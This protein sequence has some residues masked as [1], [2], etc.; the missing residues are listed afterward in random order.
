MC[1]GSALR[2]IPGE[3]A[4]KLL[5]FAAALALAMLTARLGFWQLDRASQKRQLYESQV[6]QRALAPLTQDELA[7]TPAQAFTQ[8]YRLVVLQGQW[9]SAYTVHLDNRLMNGRTGFYVLTPLRLADGGVVLVQRGWVPRD[10]RDRARL[11]TPAAPPGTVRV[12]GRVAPALGRLYEFDATSDG[13]I[14]QNLDIESFARETGLALRPLAV[15][16]EDG[17]EPPQDGL[18]RQWP[19]PSAD[20]QKHHGYAFQWFALSALTLSLYVWF[21]VIRPRRRRAT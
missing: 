21:Q 2:L 16:Q 4:R 6:R 18:L 20:L 14:R 17:D 19:T 1:G 8:R 3:K 10:M 5:V 15:V 7:G 9:L 13:P 11:V 12:L